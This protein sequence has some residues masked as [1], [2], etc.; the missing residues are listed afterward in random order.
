AAVVDVPGPGAVGGGHRHGTRDQD[1]HS[2]CYHEPAF[3]SV[4]M[5]HSRPIMT[6]DRRF[7]VVTPPRNRLFIITLIYRVFV[8]VACSGPSCIFEGIFSPFPRYPPA[9]PC[10]PHL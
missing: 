1:E 4:L 10:S 9:F 3:H 6:S 7:P 2:R 5:F 8:T